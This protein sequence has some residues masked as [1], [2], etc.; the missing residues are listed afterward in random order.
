[1]S[2]QESK[3]TKN[4]REE[5]IAPCNSSTNLLN[6]HNQYVFQSET[7]FGTQLHNLC[8]PLLLSCLWSMDALFC[9][10]CGVLFSETLQWLVHLSQGFFGGRLLFW[11]SP[12]K[13]HWWFCQ[14]EEHSQF[15]AWE[16]WT[17][18]I[19]LVQWRLCRIAACFW[20]V[21]NVIQL[22]FQ[23]LCALFWHAWTDRHNCIDWVVCC[24]MSVKVTPLREREKLGKKT[25][26]AFL[27]LW[28]RPPLH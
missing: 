24:T 22:C 16:N 21:Q 12:L 23:K 20:G 4:N 13:Q 5:N 6:H 11:H 28:F 18:M 26:S 17:R 14:T 19:L 8:C 1:M 7:F 2:W 27:S 10:F 15:S 3:R 25:Y 9:S